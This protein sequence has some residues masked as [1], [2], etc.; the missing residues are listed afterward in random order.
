MLLVSR[1]D[2]ARASRTGPS[3]YRLFQRAIR[4][5]TA[6]AG[7]DLELAGRR[8]EGNVS[9]RLFLSGLLRQHLDAAGDNPLIDQARPDHTVV[10]GRVERESGIGVRRDS[11]SVHGQSN[12]GNQKCQTQKLLVH[13]LNPFGM[14]VHFLLFVHGLLIVGPR[15]INLLSLGTRFGFTGLPILVVVTQK[16]TVVLP[17]V[18][19]G[20]VGRF[21][22]SN[23]FLRSRRNRR[24][25]GRQSPYR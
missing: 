15:L 12:T 23:Q 11:A 3:L 7:N 4:T 18:H 1:A 2:T 24:S 13:Q 22:C 10:S 17:I 9:K 6:A 25:R 19:R 5:G 21:L 20:Q 16:N 8:G 14:F